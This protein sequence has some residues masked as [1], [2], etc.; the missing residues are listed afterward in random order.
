MADTTFVDGSLAQSN[1]IVA[2][3]LNDVNY[4]T[5]KGL[6]TQM[7]V[8]GG[9]GTL[10]V[11]TTATGSGS[12]VRATAPTLTTVTVSGGGIAVTGNSTI[13]GTLGGLTGLTVAS[14]GVTVTAGDAKIA[15]TAKL[16]LD[17]GGDT[18]IV[19][20]TANIMSLFGGGVELLKL[21]VPVSTST[22]LV[23]A[24]G[25]GI[26]IGAAT[27]R[28]TTEGTNKLDIFDGTAP[29]GTLANGISLY[30]TAGELRVMDAAGNATL[31]SPHD[32]DTNEWVYDCVDKDGKRLRI[33]MEQMMKFLD[34]KFGTDFVQHI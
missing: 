9:S 32:K 7:L 4:V 31:L 2:A 18:Y 13:T 26:K 6:T 29:I 21:G 12:P 30:S 22:V 11:W 20:S 10:A 16:Y 8:G 23:T 15:A 3:W 24:S 1:R 17:G 33:K 27:G 28:A 25:V 34:E 5:Y 19:E 14:G